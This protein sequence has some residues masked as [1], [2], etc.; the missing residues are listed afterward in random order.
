MRRLLAG[1]LAA[2]T[3]AGFALIGGTWLYLVLE[4]RLFH[5]GPRSILMQAFDRVLEPSLILLGGLVAMACGFALARADAGGKVRKLL[6]AG[7]AMLPSV[8]VGS[9]AA[10]WI[11]QRLFL[12]AYVIN[13]NDMLLAI[14]GLGVGLSS[15]AAT[16][17]LSLHRR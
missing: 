6:L 8:L 7:V 5:T 2:M 10:F 4:E 15:V 11:V 14:G 16:L 1:A 12:V 17:W 13:P 3:G 9:Y